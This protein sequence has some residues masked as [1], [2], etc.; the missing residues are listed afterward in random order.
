MYGVRICSFHDADGEVT[1]F[2]GRVWRFE[3]SKMF[4]PT[5][6]GKTGVALKN[7]AMTGAFWEAFYDWYEA[8]YGLLPWREEERETARMIA[9]GRLVKVGRNLVPKE[10][11]ARIVAEDTG[12]ERSD[13]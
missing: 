8:K 13:G 2:R 11:L 4:G 9:D 12:G 5:L 10:M 7:Q 6:V 3:F 1:D